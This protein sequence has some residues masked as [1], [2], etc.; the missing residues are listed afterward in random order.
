MT[1]PILIRLLVMRIVASSLLGFSLKLMI[2][3]PDESSSS[4]IDFNW[5]LSREKKATS[6][7]LTSA[8]HTSSKM[9]SKKP[10]TNPQSMT[11]IKKKENGWM[12]KMLVLM[13]QITADDQ[14]GRSSSACCSPLVVPDE[15][16]SFDDDSSWVKSSSPPGLESRRSSI[17]KLLATTS[18][19]LRSIPSLSWYLRWVSLPSMNTWLPFFSCFSARSARARHATTS[20]H[21]VWVCQ[22]PFLSL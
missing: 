16:E 4:S 10:H 7:P 19:T 8:E 15:D 18:V 6:E 9:S 17:Q 5:L 3:S 2:L 12:S 21:S 13:K 1:I 22:S 14:N 20:C 11:V